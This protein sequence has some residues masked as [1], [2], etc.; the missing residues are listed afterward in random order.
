M[1]KLTWRCWRNWLPSPFLSIANSFR[2]IEDSIGVE[3]LGRASADQGNDDEDEII[4]ET[5]RFGN[6]M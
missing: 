6:L 1:T 2:S 4:D 5:D 3:I